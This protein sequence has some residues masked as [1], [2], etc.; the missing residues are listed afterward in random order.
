MNILHVSPYYAPA[1][2]YGGVVSAVA[3]LARAQAATHRVDVLTTDTLRPGAR[4]RNLFEM[5]DGVTVHRVRNQ[6]EGLRRLN[7]STPTSMGET[8]AQLH[9]TVIHCHELRTVENLIITSRVKN[10]PLILSPHGTLTQKTGRSIMKK[11][12]DRL[13][14]HR[15]V[16]AFQGVAALTEN[17]ADD[18]YQL[19]KLLGLPP[20]LVEIIPNGVS[21]PNRWR[22][23]ERPYP[24]PDT[25]GFF[26]LLFLGRL[27][28][29][30][31]VQFLIPA[32]IKANIP[33]TRL[34]I[35]GPDEGMLQKL[36]A[37]ASASELN[38]RIIFTG[39][40]EGEAREAIM[41]N[42]DVFVLPAEGEG[43]SMASLEAMAMG[44]PVILTPGCNL[45]DAEKRT[46]GLIVE[47]D[48]DAICA[49]LQSLM[50]D[51]QRRARSGIAGRAWMAESFG[52]GAVS[53][54]MISFY[55]KLLQSR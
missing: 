39:Y 14:G 41:R 36:Q 26:N 9:P 31:G 32:F 42:A 27:H 34:I 52:W 11:G 55:E 43:L 40:L 51:A 20:P 17:E 53:A 54:R 2:S 22:F 13:F 48:S 33:N 21:L 35:V 18:V 45:P 4:T 8:F 44:I 7:L 47:R 15:L 19:W 38:D 50:M 23:T 5:I 29:R 37:L 46:A 30:K 1:W 12:W 28:E 3:G 6:V 16:S 10:I 49:A 25:D 24:Q